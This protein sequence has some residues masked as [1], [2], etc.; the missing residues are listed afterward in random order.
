M[1]FVNSNES[2]HE[3]LLSLILMIE[4]KTK[5]PE[6]SWKPIKWI[7]TFQYSKEDFNFFMLIIGAIAIAPYGILI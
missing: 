6:N 4:D 5:N 3:R 7:G 2:E 1:L